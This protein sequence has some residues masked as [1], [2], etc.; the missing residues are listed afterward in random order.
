[1]SAKILVQSGIAA[2]TSH[3]IERNV[4]RVGSDPGMDLTVPCDVLDKHALTLEYRDGVYRVHNR[5]TVQV[6]LG[7]RTV[8]PGHSD[9]WH[10]T[11]LLEL[12]GLIQL[13]LEVDGDPAPAPPPLFSPALVSASLDNDGPDESVPASSQSQPSDAPD[14]ANASGAPVGQPTPSSSST[15]LQVGVIV[16][17]V[18]GCVLLLAR[19]RMRRSADSAVSVPRFDVIVDQAREKSDSTTQSLLRHV[20]YA[21]SAMIRGNTKAARQRY[22]S[23]RSMLLAN[24]DPA[25]IES[26]STPDP[27][28]QQMM[29]WVEYRLGQL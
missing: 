5:C 8:S 26:Q 20:Q 27:L 18:L 25:I 19:D 3:W 9:Q 12:P 16:V 28:Q 7:G 15:M 17:C 24:P 4:V 10:D 13:A 2:G 1:M 11:D 22:A 21:E 14:R 23:V 6:Y 29:Q